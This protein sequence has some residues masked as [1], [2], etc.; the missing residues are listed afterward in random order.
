MARK[1]IIELTETQARTVL[2]AV[3]E[4]FRLRMGQPAELANGLAFLGYK[5]DPEKPLEF[6][7]RIYKRNAIQE[8][9]KA[10]LHIAFPDYGTPVEI[11]P[12]THIASDIWSA[13]R[14]AL[15]PKESDGFCS[16]PF[17]MGPEPMPKITVEG[18]EEDGK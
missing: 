5:K 10:M 16:E 12:E 18:G 13:L 3:E 7:R 15:R 9:I 2:A 6:D 8:V 14:Y 17:Q 11:T 1:V 4:W